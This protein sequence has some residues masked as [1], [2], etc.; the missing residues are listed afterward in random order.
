MNMSENVAV[1]HMLFYHTIQLPSGKPLSVPDL[2]EAAH[3]AEP[4]AGL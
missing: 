1:L 4:S 2:I 3:I